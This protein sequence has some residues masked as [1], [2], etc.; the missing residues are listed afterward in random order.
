MKYSFEEPNKKFRQGVILQFPN[1]TKDWHIS[2]DSS[3]YTFGECLKRGTSRANCG[4]PPSF[5]K[6]RT[7]PSPGKSAGP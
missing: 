7:A 6:N 5:Q 3:N 2:V 4:P 1:W